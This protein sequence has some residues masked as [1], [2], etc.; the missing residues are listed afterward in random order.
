MPLMQTQEEREARLKIP[1]SDW[2]N[3]YDIEWEGSAHAFTVNLVEQL[4]LDRLKTILHCLIQSDNLDPQQVA[5]FCRR[6]DL[7]QGHW[8]AGDE[9]PLRAYY[10]DTIA[11]LS[12]SRYQLDKR[13]VRLTLLLDKGADEQGI[14]FVQDDQHHSFDD[15]NQLLTETDEQALVL[16][17]AP[18]S[19]KSTLL[20]RLQLEQ[21]WTQLESSDGIVPFFVSLNRYRAPQKGAPLPSPYDWLQIQWQTYSK[22]DLP[23]SGLFEKGQI[24]LLLDGLNEMPH[25]DPSDYRDRILQWQYFLQET[26]QYGNRV[27]FSC[28]SLD[29]SAP[30]GSA[31]V[32]VRQ[33]QVEPLSNEQIKI[34]ITT[35]LGEKGETIWAKIGG[36]EAQLALF[37]S[38]FYARLL[39]DQVEATGEMPQGRAALITGSVRRA[40][41]REVQRREHRL[42]QAGEL[43]TDRD[44]RRIFKGHWGANDF[45]LPTRS[46]LIPKL[47]QLAYQMQT[48]DEDA[49]MVGHVLVDEDTALD[50]LDD[51]QADELLQAGVQLNILDLDEVAEEVKFFHQLVQE[52]FAGRM[53]AKTPEPERV[54]VVWHVDEV[55][56]TLAERLETLAVGDPLP[57]L[58]A[59]GWEETS[60]LA[61]AMTKQPEAYV[62][63]LMAVN[64]PLAARCAN[65]VEVRV[66]DKLKGEIQQA[67]LERIADT[68]ADLRARIVAAEALGELG[69]PRFERKEG[70]FGVYLLPPMVQIEGEIYEIGDDKSQYD[71]EKPAHKV[72]IEPFEMGMFPVTNAEYGLFME[73]GG[74]EDERWWQTEAAKVWLRGE[75]NNQGQITYYENFVKQLHGMTESAIRGLNV[76]PEQIDTM[77][78]LKKMSP[79]E[80]AKLLE[81][82]FPAGIL[83]REPEYW[84][85]TRFNH[86]ARPVVGITWFEALAYCA[87]LSAQTGKLFDLPTEAEWEAAAGGKEKR[88]YAY[89]GEFNAGICNTFET[90]IR[91]TTPIGIFPQGNTPAGIQ[92]LSGNVWEWTTSQYQDYPYKKEDGREEREDGEAR[93]V[94][95]GGSWGLNQ[96]NARSA[97]RGDDVPNYRSSLGGFRVVVRPP[98]Q[99]H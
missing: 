83:H 11:K 88:Q 98:S 23:F 6:I 62:R 54:R 48:G 34:F 25:Q 70:E 12:Q 28:R 53:L 68:Q 49:I 40:L 46:K 64:L 1:L 71:F 85:D 9:N 77:L 29:Y 91:G 81:E 18:G 39:V 7:V 78:Q 52:Y 22:T 84:Q 4:S 56:P 67:L 26:Q 73:A 17:G 10:D 20:R 2:S 89:V 30:L 31:A 13:F 50:L 16:L 24:L 5:E 43:L 66:S 59:T 95:R 35:Y 15:L 8:R 87:W 19:G 74:Y 58:P 60:V 45:A 57:P 38:P 94:V 27:L 99:D 37:A 14:R 86:P 42:F 33:I 21:C 41:Y 90:H 47:E 36:D 55:S 76:T 44:Y 3:Y 72:A 82:Q 65:S 96:V 93:R 32:P 63:Q 69:D 79:E 97:Y 61:V 75:G 92:D 80:L 51:E